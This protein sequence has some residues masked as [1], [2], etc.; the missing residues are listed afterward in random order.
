MILDYKTPH[1]AVNNCASTANAVSL[2]DNRVLCRVL[3]RWK[4]FLD[5]RDTSQMPHLA[6]DG[7]FEPHVTEALCDNIKPGMTCVDIGACFGYSTMLMA[8]MVG[9]TGRVYAYEPHPRCFHMLKRN[10]EMNGFCPRAMPCPDALGD[11]DGSGSLALHRFRYNAATLSE[12]AKRSYG[13]SEQVDVKIVALAGRLEQIAR[14]DFYNL[15]TEG[16]EPQVYAGMRNLFKLKRHI[17]VL[18]RFNPKWYADA[19][20]FVAQILGDGFQCIRIRIDGER[21]P[22][23]EAEQ[24]MRPARSDI[25]MT[26]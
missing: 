7:I 8:E 2:P 21:E 4:I 15:S 16:Y 13:D 3:G 26:L 25:L 11:V 18:M 14:P 17:T 24:F 10:L 23:T 9:S 20:A 6:M 22:L 5:G 1:E 12:K 19:N